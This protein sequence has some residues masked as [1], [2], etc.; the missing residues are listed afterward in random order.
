[1]NSTG[2]IF[3]GATTMT[4]TGTPLIICTN[5]SATARTISPQAITEANSISFRITAGTG[6]F[7][8]S[9]N[10]SVRDIDFTDGTNP[11]GYGGAFQGGN[12]NVY[13]NFKAS[14]NMTQS[15]FNNALTFIA[16]SGTKTITTAG[17]TFDRPFTFNGV[18]GT[19]QLQDALT[20]GSTRT[21][22]L[23][24]GT[25]DLSSYTMTTSIFSSSNSNVRTLAFGTGKIVVTGNNATVCQTNTGT[26]LTITGSKRV[27]LSYSGGT[28]TRTISG[29]TNATLIE[30]T[31]LLDYFI[32]AGTDTV[33]FNGSR[34]YGTIDFSN[35]GTSTFTGSFTNLPVLIYGNLVLKS[36][37]VVGSG[38]NGVEMRATSG[39]K[40]ITTAG[41]TID[42][43]LNFNGVGG[44]WAFQDALTMGPLATSI[45]VFTSG[46]IQFKAG[47]TNTVLDFFTTGTTQ[48][49]LQSTIPGTQAT[50]YQT[51]GDNSVSYLTIQ[52]SNATGGATWQAYAS[53]FNINAG[54]NTGWDG[55][56]ISD[57]AIGAAGNVSYSLAINLTG[58]SS[59]GAVGTVSIAARTFGLTGDLAVGNVGDVLP[60]YWKP[61]ND[62]QTASW[63]QINTEN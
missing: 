13:G 8:I 47:T 46:T 44:T 61:I 59:M 45:I 34:G 50:I 27:E 54:N 43:Q 42:F 41:Q 63:E 37:M 52:D 14:T 6:T 7:A 55:L 5:S 38:T 39:T 15:A 26:N 21:V 58:A 9:N 29:A 24:N 51:T 28:G 53:N 62:T 11:T 22:T 12:N 60:V 25:L 23:T 56:S 33:T 32:T 40:T 3:T 18:G 36:G 49:Y 10:Q 17:V 30:G 57:Y 1:L 31:N 4:V 20:V 35:G 2:T 19:W 48:K 16:T